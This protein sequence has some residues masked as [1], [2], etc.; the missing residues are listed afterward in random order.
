MFEF[1]Q[2]YI[3]SIITLSKMSVLCSFITWHSKLFHACNKTIYICQN[4]KF[5]FLHFIPFFF[6]CVHVY[7]VALSFNQS[8][9]SR[10]QEI[11]ININIYWYFINMHIFYKLVYEDIGFLAMA[12]NELHH[13]SHYWECHWHGG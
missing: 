7:F 5:R 11:F 8:H 10:L 13:Y 6:L 1:L 3:P 12:V 9:S 2:L 4:A